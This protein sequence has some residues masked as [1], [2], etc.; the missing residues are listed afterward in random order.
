MLRQHTA[1]VPDPKGTRSTDGS[2]RDAVRRLVVERGHL[3]ITN[4]LLRHEAK[5]HMNIAASALSYMTR[6][7]EVHRAE[8]AGLP[9]HW[10]ASAELAQRWRATTKPPQ[11]P[12]PRFRQRM[13]KMDRVREPTEAQ[14]VAMVNKHPVVHIARRADTADTPANTPSHVQVQRVP[15]PTH[16][17]RYQ[18]AP[19]ERPAGAGFAAA[20]IGRDITTGRAWRQPG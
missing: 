19:G 17:V 13:V 12:T 2:V 15:A 16:D 9:L 8:I 18:C 20:G 11:Q 6:K 14:N 10:F 4:E 7:G 5:C 1:G 3:G